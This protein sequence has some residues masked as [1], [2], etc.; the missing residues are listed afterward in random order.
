M[1]VRNTVIAVIAGMLM[2]GG[3]SAAELKVL[4][5]GAMKAVVLALAPQFESQGHKLTVDNDTAGGLTKRIEGGETFDV[6]VITPGAIDG[7]I[8]KGKVAAGTRTNLSRVGIGVM[9]K[10]GAPK[11]DIG[12]VE[13]FK[14]A[15]V[16]AKSVAYIDPESG[17]SS[18]IYL[19]GLFEKLGIADVIKPKAKLKRGG[20]VADLIVSGDAEL[21]LHQ[22][23]E[24]LPAK[25]VTL[26]GPVPAEIQ[27]YTVYAGGISA[28][29]KDADAAKAL[30][31]LLSGPSAATVLRE[32][33][34]ERPS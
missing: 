18:G 5:T 20:Y 10:E 1:R 32:K 15:L 28:T 17:G 29:A 30:I 4:T 9:V 21:G 11:P 31:G 23:S 13:A 19:A 3:A 22:I 24:I 14:Q 7:L 6:A 25:G 12:N 2:S 8:A 16:A 27:N 34:M 33:G 26:V